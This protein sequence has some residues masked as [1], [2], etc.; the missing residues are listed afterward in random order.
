M[1]DADQQFI[2]DHM[3]QAVVDHLE[4]IQIEK[5]H[6]EHGLQVAAAMLD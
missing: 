4:A 5:E 1:G 3:A 6:G 2:A